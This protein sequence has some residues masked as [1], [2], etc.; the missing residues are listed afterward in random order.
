MNSDVATSV[1]KTL[2]FGTEIDPYLLQAFSTGLYSTYWKDYITDL[3]D[4]SRR[5]FVYNANLPLGIMLALKTNDKLTIQE[6][7]YRINNVDLNLTTGEATLELL[8]DV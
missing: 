8:N 2:N 7:N 3:Y 5:L 4:A 6:R 1:T